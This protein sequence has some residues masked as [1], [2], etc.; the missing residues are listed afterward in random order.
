MKTLVKLL[1]FV[2]CFGILAGCQKDE[3]IYSED[4]FDKSAKMNKHRAHGL[5]QYRC[6]FMKDYNNL[7][8][9]YRI[10]G[11]GPVDM[12]F[13]PGW[14]N[15]LE[16]YTKQFDYF[17]DKA[18][19][20]YIDLPGH[21]QSDA[22][23]PNNPLDPDSE[24]LAYTQEL[25]IDAI[26]TV[27]KKEG[28]K[29]F[30]GVGFSW[31]GAILK[32]FEM[33]YPGMIKQ[34]ICLDISIPTWP[35][36]NE[37]ICEQEYIVQSSKTYEERLAGLPGLIPLETAPEGLWEFGL[38]CLEHSSE[39]MANAIY[40]WLGEEN[41]QPYPWDIPIL[42]V[43]NEMEDAL[44]N[45]TRSHYPGCEIVVLEGDWHVWPYQ[46]VIQWAYQDAVNQLMDDFMED[47]PG[48]KY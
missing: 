4:A 2:A 25:M 7:K 9:N 35:P 24:G 37:A 40:H 18:R 39:I 21:G 46:H 22:P 16:V 20:I 17:R 8:V 1:F 19:C 34:L 23:T 33:K 10:I 32:R 5:D 28:L 38:Q 43:Y 15:S 41:C 14:S 26:K 42:V 27:V 48:K 36:V 12:V 45:L 13:I 29:K 11:K 6:V 3:E 31:S 44:E 47:R 30:I